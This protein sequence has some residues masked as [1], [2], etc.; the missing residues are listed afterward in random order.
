MKEQEKR[1]TIG[2]LSRRTGLPVKTLR[3]WSDEG[4]LQPAARS[5]SGYRLYTADAVLRIDLLRTL[6]D[7]GLGHD[8]IRKV[9]RHDLSLADAL[10]L[11]LVAVEAHAAALQRVAAALRA[12][13]RGDPAEP[14]ESDVRRLCAVTRFTNEERRA[15]IEKFYAQVAEGLPIDEKWQKS[16]IDASTPRLPDTP[17]AEQLDA[18][19]ELAELVADPSFIASLRAAAKQSWEPGLDLPAL[20]AANDRA[21]AAAAALRAR[22]VSP[23]SDEARALAYAFADDLAAASK[24]PADDTFRRSIRRRYETHDPRASHYWT[25]VAR[26]NGAPASRKVDDWSFVAAAAKLHLPA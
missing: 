13:L 26:I 9:L 7:A 14:T 6:R 4:L 17:T 16:M 1:L 11:H 2:D 12:A 23:E 22:G 8:A 25:L 5:R 21:L 24:K 3:F 10:R 15:V 20:N 19:I 18:W